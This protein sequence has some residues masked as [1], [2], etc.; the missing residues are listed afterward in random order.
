M[1]VSAAAATLCAAALTA[2]PQMPQGPPPQ[3]PRFRVATN[4]VQVDVYP[5]SG[6]R[7]VTDLTAG[8]F[9]VL[10][11][12]KLQ[13]IEAFQHIT[14]R[15]PTSQ[16]LRVEPSTVEAANQLAA[17]PTRRVFVLFL[18]TYHVEGIAALQ[19]RQP[20]VNLLT[21]V[22]GQ[23]DVVAVMTPEMAAGDLT[24]TTRTQSIEALLARNWDWGRRGQLTARDP[25]EDQYENCYPASLSEPRQDTLAGKMIDRRREKLALDAL[26][27][28]VVHLE[29]LRE[30]RKAVIAV[31][32]GWRL[33]RED[34]TMLADSTMS[35]PGVFV[36]PGGKLGVGTDPRLGPVGSQTA[37]E[38]DRLFLAFLDNDR[39]F[40]TLL[41]DANRANV[42]FYPVDPRGLPAGDTPLGPS[43]PIS[44]DRD[45]AQLHGRIESL[46]TMAVATDGIAVINGNDIDRGLRRIV[47]DLTSYYLLGYSSTNTKPDG[48]F[49]RIT[50]RVKRPGVVVRARRG[51]RAPSEADLAVRGATGGAAG[52]GPAPAAGESEAAANTALAALAMIRTDVPVHY[53][54]GYAWRAGD[55]APGAQAPAWPVAQLWIAGELDPAR[56]AAEGWGDG[57]EGTI[58]VT[59]ASRQTV[60]SATAGFSRAVRASRVLLPDGAALGPGTYDVRVSTKSA[61]GRA[62]PTETFRVTVPAVPAGPD[63]LLLGQPALSRR[64][65][66][67]GTAF[68]PAGDLR[69]RRQEWIRIEVARTGALEEV[70]AR[71]LGRSG[72]ALDIPVKVGQRQDGATSWISAEVAL[73]PLAP[74]DYLIEIEARGITRTER[75]L[76]AFRIVP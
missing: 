65:P 20:L 76:A 67:T 56:A 39:D 66:F 33:F 49:R 27:D 62:A 10:E 23:D 14:L 61:E 5:T 60:G 72:R 12:N 6:D 34:R 2:H 75:V 51:Y 15:A 41:D 38:R 17:D 9:E 44:I 30:G 37:C 53:Q 43:S 11:D 50:V 18:D 70:T 35:P 3:Q 32:D 8:D 69:F 1:V 22:V 36:G 74:G 64:G 47:D 68:L 63:V 19:V 13:K 73:A 31:S 26:R 59:N 29:G 42:S 48:R 7:P 71:I 24:F 54:A 40:R 4:F 25:Q 28:L 45:M 58:T 21:R 46:Q 16:E 55:V 57:G 52:A